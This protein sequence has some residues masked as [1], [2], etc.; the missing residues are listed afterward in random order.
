MDKKVERFDKRNLLN[1]LSGKE[2]LKLTKSY[3]KSEKCV[4]DKFAMQHPAPYLLKDTMKMISM[5]TKSGM[6]VLDPFAGVGTTL[7][8]CSRLNRKGVGIELNDKYVKLTNERLQAEKAK[9]NQKIVKGDSLK[10]LEKIKT[11]FDYC[12]TSPPYH[13]I[14]KNNGAGLRKE[15]NKFRSGARTGIDYYSE[16]KNDL[17]NQD[18]YEDFLIKL[19]EIS[20]LIRNRLKA[21]GY[22][23][24]ILSDF[25]VNKREVNV[26]GDVISS[27][28]EIGFNF[29]GTQILLQ[30]NKPLFPFGYPYAFKINHHHQ[31]LMHFRKPKVLN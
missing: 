25:T 24:F 7:L 27:M 11:T 12:V 23:T 13:N 14:L 5:F 30:D 6:K 9:T 8:A 21:G 10:V 28:L 17:G 4:E 19:Q 29:E 1:D 15:N 31:N 16:S 22:L 3:L 20:V 18:T 2:W 26:Q